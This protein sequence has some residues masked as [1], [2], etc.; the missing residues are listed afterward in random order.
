MIIQGML[1]NG[2]HVITSN[3]VHNSV[4]RPLYHK[5]H[6]GEID[7]TY[8][9]FDDHGYIDPDDVRKAFRRNT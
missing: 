9:P 1:R 4:L 2:D 6:D 3:V 8:I 7:V 5:M